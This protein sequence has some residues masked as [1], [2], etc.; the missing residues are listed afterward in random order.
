MGVT[1]KVVPHIGEG[2]T[3]R[4]EIEQ[5]VSDVK[6]NKGQAQDLVTSKRAIKTSVLAEHGNTI[7]LGGLISDNTSYSR[8]SIPGLG[9][10]PGIGAF[11]P[12]RW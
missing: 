11:V 12:L 4:L 6:A 5:E 1:L 9:A 8:Q 10:I 7:V 3:I 2:G